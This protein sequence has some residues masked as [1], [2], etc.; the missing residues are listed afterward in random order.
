MPKKHKR[1]ALIVGA[2]GREH[3]FAWKFHQEGIQVF[4]TDVAGDPG[5]VPNAGMEQIATYVPL[6]SLEEAAK[7]A[8][9]QKIDLAVF[10]PEKY[11]VAGGVDIFTAAGVRAF[12][13]TKAAAQLEG[14]KSFAKRLMKYA[15]VPTAGFQEFESFDAA[16]GYLKQQ[17]GRSLVL[18]ADGLAAGKGVIMCT[19]PDRAKNLEDQLSAARGMMVGDDFEGAGK[20]MIVEEVLGGEEASILALVGPGGLCILPS[21]Q[22]HKR[23][24]NN[25]E[26]LNTGG[27]GAYSPAPVVTGAVLD[28][29]VDDILLPTVHGM[30]RKKMPYTGVLYAGLMIKNGKPS[31]LEFNVRAGDPEIQPVGMRV[32]SSLFD[33]CIACCDGTIDKYNLEVDEN[34]AHGVVM[35]SGGYPGKYEKGKVITGLDDVPEGVVVFHAGTR[36]DGDKIL[37]NGGRVLCVTGTGKTHKEAND[38]AYKVVG[39][40]VDFEGAHYRKD[41]G[42]RAFLERA[43]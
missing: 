1:S 40:M 17:E 4:Y 38:A 14:S 39:N 22:D 33:A 18:K 13:P 6:A 16:E 29:V 3:A 12:G 31:V 42:Q 19:N 28:Q 35:A 7:F 8:Q 24:L 9:D 5:F 2:G 30:A 20:R 25:D 36:R 23:A 43:G 37:T 32:K 34:A 15:G 27:M 10:G 41:I 21:S 26:G 11:L